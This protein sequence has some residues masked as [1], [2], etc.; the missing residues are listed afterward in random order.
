[1]LYVFLVV[2]S[3]DYLVSETNITVSAGVADA[4][5]TQIS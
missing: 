4:Q 3:S 2:N 1:M 5:N